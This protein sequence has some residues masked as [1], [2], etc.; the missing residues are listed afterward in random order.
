MYRSRIG[1][2]AGGPLCRNSHPLCRLKDPA[3]VYMTSCRLSSCKT[4]VYYA[5]NPRE[6]VK[7]YGKKERTARYIRGKYSYKTGSMTGILKKKLK[8][9]S[10]KE[11][12]KE[13]RLIMLYKGLKGA[14][15]YIRMTLSS[16]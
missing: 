13:S 3:V 9:E 6:R 4:G 7:Q 14:E 11:K 2:L 12:K 1:T 5:D 8:W 16:N 15:V 10:L